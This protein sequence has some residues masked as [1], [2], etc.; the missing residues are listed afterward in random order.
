MNLN[1]TIALP[2]IGLMFSNMFLGEVIAESSLSLLNPVA[3]TAGACRNASS[4]SVVLYSD[5]L[6][7][8]DG[9]CTFKNIEMLPTRSKQA[10]VINASCSVDER[11]KE[12]ARFIVAYED[13]SV[14]LSL[15]SLGKGM[16]FFTKN[17][18]IPRNLVLGFNCLD[19]NP[20]YKNNISASSKFT[21]Y[22]SNNEKALHDIG[23]IIEV[24]T[25][26]YNLNWNVGDIDGV[27]GKKTRKAIQDYKRQVGLRVTG[28]I[29]YDLLESL[30]T[31]EK[32]RIW[33]AIAYR[34]DGGSATV[35]NHTSRQGAH[36]DVVRRCVQLG[37]RHQNQCRKGVIT[38]INSQCIGLAYYETRRRQGT[39]TGF[40]NDVNSARTDTI[41]N[42]R[43]KTR[44]KC[45]L[46]TAICADGSHQ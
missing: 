28:K 20:T 5:A 4:N 25:H 45:K 29:T 6:R 39:I 33:G 43:I 22:N 21:I 10:F 41:S 8:G 12:K 17:R 24:Q 30:R 38:F 46:R 9:G 32:P 31:A 11:M 14:R 2:F 3:N 23:S 35:T 34:G 44:G 42:C 19:R 26:L 18:Q 16:T 27:L 36:D 40:G 15:N 1:K 37:G 13:K 7:L